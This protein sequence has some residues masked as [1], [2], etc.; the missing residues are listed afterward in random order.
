MVLCLL[1]AANW[2]IDYRWSAAA[3]VIKQLQRK[4]IICNLRGWTA[5]GDRSMDSERR[6]FVRTAGSAGILALLVA[7]GFL[8]VGEARADLWNKPA[9]DAESLE[10]ALSAL[11]DSP[12]SE[13]AGVTIVA[14]D[15][16]ENGAVVPVGVIATM[17]GVE[18]I[19]ILCE[20]NPHP[21]AAIYEIPAGTHADVK[22]RVKMAQT[23]N[24]LVL[25]KA[26]G[27]I[28]MARKEIKVTRGGCGG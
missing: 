3:L 21:L 15:I 26:G 2:T 27:R 1:V 22:T 7:R 11:V 23:S 17:K 16:A 10:D 28:H 18:S 13:S 14:P 4:R 25:V 9:F 24:V 8:T 19:A 5:Q 20:K 6:T 12:S